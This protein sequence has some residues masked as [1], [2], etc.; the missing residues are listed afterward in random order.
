MSS[1]FN[2]A[3]TRK[4]RHGLLTWFDAHARDLPWRL[5]RDPYAIWVSEI[6]LQQT[7][8]NAV[9]DHYARFMDRFPT[10]QSLA[11][12]EEP[13]VLA[14]WSG[15]GYYRRAR[16]LYKAAKFVVNQM[17]GKIPETAEGLRELPGIGTYTSAAIA[18][19]AFGERA[20]VVDGN[21]ERVVMR[22][23]ALEPT[24]NGNAS[25]LGRAIRETAQ[26]LLDRYR[27]GDAN[28]AM[29]ELGATI[30]LP[31]NPLCLQ[32][33]VEK[34]CRT[35]GEHATAPAKESVS[36]QTS[37]ALLRR[38]KRKQVEVL[39]EQRPHEASLMAGMWELPQLDSAKAASDRLLFSV[40]HSITTTNYQV[41][42]LAFEPEEERT[43]PRRE[44]RKWVGV[45]ALPDL[46]LTG[47]ARKV[48]KRLHLLP[49]SPVHSISST[50]KAS[51]GASHSSPEPFV[52]K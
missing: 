2:A 49:G 46:P 3:Q 31:R 27:P 36:S 43:L 10:M 34:L 52:G 35:R 40:R 14:I 13:E 4:F 17:S 38:V 18:S 15:L 5:T 1:S 21:V 50:T 33:P 29:M 26:A 20:A 23:A 45:E 16:M 11:Q 28:Q 39:L 7:R 6:M 22:L 42:V 37:Y 32:C 41:S 25:A 48:L 12:A 9:L 8:V 51:T 47:L 30:C 24:T 19:I 44:T